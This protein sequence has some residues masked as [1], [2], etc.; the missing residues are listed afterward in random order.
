MKL[1]LFDIDGT[2][3]LTRGQGRRLIEE[4]LSTLCGRPIT[5]EHVAFSGKTDPQIVQEILL[6]NGLSK[7]DAAAFVPQALA[8]YLEKAHEAIAPQHIDVLPGVP[9]L[10]EHLAARDDVQLALLT[11][12]HQVTAYLKLEAAGLAQY[13][14]FGAFGSDHADRYEL[15]PVAVHRAFTHTGHTYAGKDVVIIGDSEHDVRCGR[16]I[17]AFSVAVCT[18]FTERATLAAETPDLLLDD[19]CDPGYFLSQ[20]MNHTKSD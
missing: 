16:G 3:L 11:G 7:Q 15:P 18:G 12:N 5:T 8:I 4:L 2:I 17:G 1:L 20:V 9:A 13:F 19:L 14:P 6:K 10:I